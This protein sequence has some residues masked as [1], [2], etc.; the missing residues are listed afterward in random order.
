MGIDSGFSAGARTSRD[1]FHALLGQSDTSRPSSPGCG[2]LLA[3]LA[4]D[5]LTPSFSPGAGAGRRS[6]SSGSGPRR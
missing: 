3:C 5:R 6:A 1:A 4:F 2:E